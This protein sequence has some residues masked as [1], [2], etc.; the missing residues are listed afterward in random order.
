MKPIEELIALTA[1]EHAA[2][3]ALSVFPE[4]VVSWRPRER[5]LPDGRT[6]IEPGWEPSAGFVAAALAILRN[7]P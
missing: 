3:A 2:A 4:F 7:K 1:D 6:I 5:H